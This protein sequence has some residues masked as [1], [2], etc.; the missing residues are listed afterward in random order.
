VD[1]SWDA[2]G[3]TGEILGA[4]AVVITLVYLAMQIRQNT[5]ATQ[6][7]TF[8]GATNA[9][10]HINM[11][12]STDPNLVRIMA[13]EKVSM[14]DLS[15]EDQVRYSFL[16]LSLFRVRE[17]IY[18][19]HDQGITTHQSWIRELDSLRSNLQTPIVREW[20]AE[21]P[22]GFTPEFTEVVDEI[23]QEIQSAAS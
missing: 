20:W 15:S 23:I 1:I 4:A 5:K 3:A 16:L 17:T 13:Q 8:Q 12:V 14:N 18:F 10:N 2:V 22:F 21:N 6:S 19:D 11:S 7:S 9:L